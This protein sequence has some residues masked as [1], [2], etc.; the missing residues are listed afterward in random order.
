MATVRL[1]KELQDE[2]IKNAKAMFDKQMQAAR[3]ARPSHDWGEK[4]YDIL[5][6]QHVVALNAVPSY[7]LNMV[8]KIEIER[9]GSQQCGL[10]FNLLSPK[11]YPKEFP[12]TELA[13]KANYW[14]S[15]VV[16]KD[17]LLWGE[18]R[19][20][21]VRWEEGVKA[22]EEKRKAFVE[23]VQ[24]IITAHATLAPALKM[25]Q[26]LWDLIPESCKDKH[27]EIKERTKKEVE[28]DV[29]FDKLTAIA[30]AAKFGV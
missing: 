11:P 20:E 24:K 21:I 16:L 14:N 2:I 29:D 22:V 28:I 27:R 23:Q 7:F 26:P 17:N 18:L 1:S 8:G 9:V 25:W 30:T 15:E 3:D 10:E 13:K 6:G 4:I 19:A 12:E 5:F